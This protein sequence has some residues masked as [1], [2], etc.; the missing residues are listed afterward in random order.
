[1]PTLPAPIIPQNVNHLRPL[2]MQAVEEVLSDPDLGLE[3]T[4]KAKRRLRVVRGRIGVTI[5][6]SQI[7]NK[8]L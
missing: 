4:E 1:M 8:Y 6:F 5:P 7:K 3:L 2:I